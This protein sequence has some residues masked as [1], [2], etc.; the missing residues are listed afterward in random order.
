MSYKEIIEKISRIRTAKNISA[1][2]LSLRLGH[3]QTYFYRVE[4]GLIKIDLD[5]FLDILTILDVSTFEFFCPDVYKDV[6]NIK[7][8]KSLNEKET[9]AVLTLLKL[10]K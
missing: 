9:E 10:R 6:E 3:N 5:T 8:L 1:Y 4:K 7:L 2:D